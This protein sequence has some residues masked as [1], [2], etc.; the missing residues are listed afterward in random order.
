MSQE[1]RIIPVEFGTHGNGWIKFSKNWSR[2]SDG[3][4]KGH[5]FT[6]TIGED[7]RAGRTTGNWADSFPMGHVPSAER[8]ATCRTA[9][10]G[11]ASMASEQGGA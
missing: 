9:T 1:S 2:M 7:H 4:T 5:G 11:W 3:T 10:T 8:A 6:T